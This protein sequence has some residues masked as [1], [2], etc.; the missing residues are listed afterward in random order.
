MKV[1]EHKYYDWLALRCDGGKKGAFIEP[2]LALRREIVEI[3]TVS[4]DSPA[5][6]VS[7]QNNFF[8]CSRHFFS[9]AFSKIQLTGIRL[10]ISNSEENSSEHFGSSFRYGGSGGGGMEKSG[11]GANPHSMSQSKSKS[12]S[13]FFHIPGN[14]SWFY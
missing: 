1:D 14:F 5:A 7:Q 11:G 9:S 2:L 8:L 3:P 4:L 12:M 10:H 13:N 6:L